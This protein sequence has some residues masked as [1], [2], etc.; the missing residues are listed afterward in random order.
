MKFLRQLL[1]KTKP[2]Q[3]L[4][5]RLSGPKTFEIEVIDLSN[6]YLDAFW[7]AT[8]NAWHRKEGERDFFERA[9]EVTLVSDPEGRVPHATGVEIGGKVIAH[10]GHQDALRLHRRLKKL[11][12]DRIKAKCGGNL[13][14]RTGYWE[15]RLDVDMSL[16]GCE[17]AESESGS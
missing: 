17:A 14:G 16:P 10:L 15:V 11:G 1:R 4:T 3:T 8:S 5:K 2:P 7:K 13:V 6:K 9:T 12:Y